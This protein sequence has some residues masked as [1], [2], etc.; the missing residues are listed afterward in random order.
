[1][2]I[3]SA[4]SSSGVL[5]DGLAPLPVKDPEVKNGTL[6]SSEEQPLPIVQP[7]T[8]NLSYVLRS[9]G[10]RSSRVKVLMARIF[11]GFGTPSDESEESN[12]QTDSIPTLAPMRE[13]RI[14]TRIPPAMLN[15]RDL[16]MLRNHRRQVR[17]DRRRM[18][19]F[20]LYQGADKGVSSPTSAEYIDS[21]SSGQFFEIPSVGPYLNVEGLNTP[22]S[23]RSFG[24]HG[25]GYI[26]SGTSIYHCPGHH[27]YPYRTYRNPKGRAR[28]KL[29]LSRNN[30][31]TEEPVVDSYRVLLTHMSANL[32]PKSGPFRSHTSRHQ[33]KLNYF[34]SAQYS[35]I[36]MSAI[37]EATEPTSTST[38][39][40]STGAMVVAPISSALIKRCTGRVGLEASEVKFKPMLSFEYAGAAFNQRLVTI[41]WYLFE[42]YMMFPSRT[43]YANSIDKPVGEFARVNHSFW[44]YVG[45]LLNT[46]VRREW[47]FD[48]LGVI[49]TEFPRMA[50]LRGPETEGNF[51]D[52]SENVYVGEALRAVRTSCYLICKLFDSKHDRREVYQFVA[53][54]QVGRSCFEQLIELG[55]EEDGMGP[56]ARLT[57]TYVFSRVRV[58]QKMVSLLMKT[59]EQDTDYFRVHRIPLRCC[60]MIW[61][62]LVLLQEEEG[63]GLEENEIEDEEEERNLE[64]EREG[65]RLAEMEVR[66]VIALEHNTT[67]R[68]L[69]FQLFPELNTK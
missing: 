14:V 66:T 10:S 58:G 4:D 22:K 28:V 51:G 45:A 36:R 38:E 31:T 37:I 25:R 41:L 56:T 18:C 63:S 47:L 64:D 62:K 19:C 48:Y 2:I 17:Q 49:L 32:A 11:Q 8:G 59:R 29:P 68:T 34:N 15:E 33:N 43:Y 42:E 50:F 26:A 61:L 39:T 69:Y 35:S 13:R 40:T 30:Y 44:E 54:N 67:I 3:N 20:C 24:A 57:L 52:D 6:L 46:V 7:S 65:R 23:G 5:E 60:L 9:S 16:D 53:G 21:P 27:K 12:I 1:M 55:K